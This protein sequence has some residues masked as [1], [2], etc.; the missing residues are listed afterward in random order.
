MVQAAL[1]ETG[2]EEGDVL[3]VGVEKAAAA[4]DCHIH[5]ISLKSL[6]PMII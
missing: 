6:P 4:Q 1:K 2:G 3:R 5:L